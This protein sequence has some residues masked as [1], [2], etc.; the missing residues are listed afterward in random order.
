MKTT[1][2]AAFAM[3]VLLGTLAAAQEAPP[4]PTPPPQPP[5]QPVEPPPRVAPVGGGEGE[6][7]PSGAPTAVPELLARTPPVARAGELLG[8]AILDLSGRPAGRLDDLVARADGRLVALIACEDGRLVGV[9]LGELIARAKPDPQRGPDHATIRSFRLAPVSRR[10]ESAPPVEDKA[11]LDA[12]WWARLDGGTMSAPEDDGGPPP[13][14]EGP[15]GQTGEAASGDAAAGDDAAHDGDV[16]AGGGAAGGDA[17]AGDATGDAAGG[18]AHPPLST[19]AGRIALD[20]AGQPLGTFVD[21][22]V[23]IPGSR[24]AYLLVREAASVGTEGAAGA[25]GA[26]RAVAFDALLPAGAD[27]G[28]ALSIDATALRASPRVTDASRLPV[29][30]PLAPAPGSAPDRGPDASAPPPSGPTRPEPP[31]PATTPS[32]T[33]PPATPSSRPDDL[34]W[35]TEL[36]RR[37]LAELVA[38]RVAGPLVVH[39]RP[40]DFTSEQLDEDVAANLAD[41]E[42]LQRK[43]AM[44][45]AGRVHVFL[46]RDGEDML[47]TTGTDSDIA[48]STGTASV[49]QVRDF[50]GVHE[51]THLFALQFPATEDG[52]GPD[53]FV[54]EGLAT[55]MAGSDQDVPV[56]AWAATYLR[57]GR[58]PALAALRCGFPDGAPSGVHPYHVAGSFLLYLVE[59][60]GIERVKAFYVDSAEAG[61]V[62]GVP[63]A[64]LERD[65]RAMLDGLEVDPAHEAHVRDALGTGH[66]PLPQAWAAAED[67]VLFDGTSLDALEAEEP[68]CWTLRDGLL[69]GA[70]DGP[71]T[72]LHSRESFGADVGLRVRFR[73]VSGDAVQ[74]RLN[75][76]PGR[77]SQAILAAWSAYVSAGDEGGFA[78]NDG[79]KVPH[80]AW[81][82]AVFVNQGGRARLWLDGAPVLDVPDALPRQEGAVGLGVE[83][84]ELEVA[85][86]VAFAP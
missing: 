43:L 17:A 42:E 62:L 13:G 40:D 27:G 3:A 1:R 83:R 63:A 84:G 16:A 82:E 23:G 77:E 19:L 64:R 51:L 15:S 20:P 35:T 85:R 38:T 11:R 69:V 24:V 65:W 5:P 81:C 32:A 14:A 78:G 45:Y 71:F 9:P 30:P 39:L 58:L 86:I 67:A 34:A 33:T 75:R 54:T 2:P 31:S 79:V 8:A 59:R 28:L 36:D 56:H 52:G 41:F 26:L 29:A 25:G 66:E 10:L 80:G 22:V 49:H 61:M 73:L 57:T 68:S 4:Q 72:F 6:A 46:Y 76:V 74:L 48:F 53:L 18:A 7:G 47:A 44:E 60:F 70:R 21:A 55:A 50:R 12:A 37:M